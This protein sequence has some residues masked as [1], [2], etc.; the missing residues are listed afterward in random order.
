[1]LFIVGNRLFRSALLSFPNA[2]VG[3]G[4]AGVGTFYPCGTVSCPQGGQLLWANSCIPCRDFSE[5]PHRVIGGVSPGVSTRKS[6]VSISLTS[7]DVRKK[8]LSQDN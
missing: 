5:G 8:L 2:G 6:A 1:M 3:G 4:G 7:A